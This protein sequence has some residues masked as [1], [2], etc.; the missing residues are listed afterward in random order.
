MPTFNREKFSHLPFC[1]CGIAG[2]G[3]KSHSSFFPHALLALP[4]LMVVFNNSVAL[5]SETVCSYLTKGKLI[6]I[7]IVSM[8][9]FLFVTHRYKK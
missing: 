2:D 1:F 8:L 7:I 6:L 4:S 3:H 5:K 9:V